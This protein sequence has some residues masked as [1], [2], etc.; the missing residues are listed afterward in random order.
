MFCRVLSE[1]ASFLNLVR[2]ILQIKYKLIAYKLIKRIKPNPISFKILNN[3]HAMMRNANDFYLG[4]F[5]D[6]KD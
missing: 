3:I 2:L 5:Y 4:V 1:S 6:I